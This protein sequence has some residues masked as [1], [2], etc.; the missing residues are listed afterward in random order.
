VLAASV[1]AV[2]ARLMAPAEP[3]RSAPD[4]AAAASG[5]VTFGGAFTLVDHAGRTVTDRDFRGYYALVFFGFTY[6]PDVCPTTLQD[7]AHILDRLGPLAEK[8]QPMFITV[9]PERDTPP[10]MASYAQAFH[11]RIVG[12]TGTVEQVREAA[13]AYKVFFRKVDDS[14][15][16]YLMEHTAVLFLMGPEG[17]H[18]ET[19]PRE[20]PPHKMAEIVRR[21]LTGTAITPDQPQKDPS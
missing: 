7:V 6:C 15:G 11:P 2:T 1:A 19:L 12:L 9:D 14:R 20:M 10:V 4:T 8:V 21:H 5:K 17:Q 3:L 18:L 13:K 16:G